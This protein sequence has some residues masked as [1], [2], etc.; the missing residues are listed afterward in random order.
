[1]AYLP[2]LRTRLGLFGAPVFFRAAQRALIRSESFF[3]PAA[4]S[5]PLRRGF[6]SEVAAAAAELLFCFTQRARWAAAIRARAA[7]DIVRLAIDVSGADGGVLRNNAARRLSSCSICRRIATA[8]SR[9]WRDRFIMRGNI[10]H[11]NPDGKQKFVCTC[12]SGA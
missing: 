8:S 5:S 10:A 12:G 4:V 7:A 2:Y 9:D 1:M 3:R 6:C 11:Y